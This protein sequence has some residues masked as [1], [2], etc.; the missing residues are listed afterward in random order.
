V[1]IGLHADVFSIGPDP[2]SE[3]TAAVEAASSGGLEY[4]LPQ[5]FGVDA[6]TALAAVGRDVPDARF[7]TFVVPTYAR[8]PM[9]MAMQAL[10]VQAAAGGRFTLGIG[11]SHRP[12]VERAYGLSY[13]TPV[14]HMREY[15]SV[16]VPLLH[17]EKV[18][19]AGEEITS[20]GFSPLAVPD[21]VPP[22][23]LVA[24]L[25]PQM[26]RVT[27]QHADGTVLWMVGPKTIADHVVPTITAAAAAAGRPRPQVVAGLPVSVTADPDEA[28]E[29]ATGALALYGELPS[30][31]AMLD[32]EGVEGPADIAVIGDEEAVA[33]QLRHV[34]DVGATALVVHVLGSPEDRRRTTALLCEL[35]T[36]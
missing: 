29:M 30:Y 33:A 5:G 20:R 6:L 35:A 27:G 25:G 21:V 12:V 18:R 14:R 34:V 36:P 28:R 13:D 9:V 24:A 26:L 10:T 15:L 17:G 22:P 7:G 3:L 31:R 11:L 2:I 19:F 32:R 8:H 23:V 1:R 4:W 16:L